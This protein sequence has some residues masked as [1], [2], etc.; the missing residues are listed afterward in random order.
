MCS[1]RATDIVR[2]CS[3]VPLGSGSSLLCNGKNSPVSL[4]T[5]VDFMAM[6]FRPLRMALARGPPTRL[7]A[8]LLLCAQKA[9]EWLGVSVLE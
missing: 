4:L 8:A 3:F 7:A 6:S 5:P 9:G 1:P 2:S